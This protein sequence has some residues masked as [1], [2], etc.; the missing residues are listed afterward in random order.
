MAWAVYAAH[1]MRRW[2][3]TGGIWVLGAAVLVMALLWVW[4]LGVESAVD[5][6]GADGGDASQSVVEDTDR[7]WVQLA[8]RRQLGYS[9]QEQEVV[10]DFYQEEQT[11]AEVVLVGLSYRGGGR[12]VGFFRINGGNTEILGADE[13][14]QGV[15]VVRV[16]KDH[17]V[18]ERDGERLELR[19]VSGDKDDLGGPNHQDDLDDQVGLD[20]QE[21]GEQL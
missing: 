17:A 2:L 8:L 5:A 10:D 18:V 16:A 6:N 9:E 14:S 15:R 4:P 12:G 11:V 13:E 1:A 20:E 7:D 3:Q 19:Q 21:Y